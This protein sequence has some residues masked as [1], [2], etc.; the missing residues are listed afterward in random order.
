MKLTNNQIGRLQ[1]TL[2][3]IFRLRDLAGM[4]KLTEQIAIDSILEIL[5][6]WQNRQEIMQLSCDFKSLYNAN[7]PIEITSERG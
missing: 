5:D 1:L 3:E 6:Y 7:V 2:A 4:G